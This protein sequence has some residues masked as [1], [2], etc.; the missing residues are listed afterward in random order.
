ATRAV[1]CQRPARQH[2]FE[3]VQQLL[4]DFEVALIAGMVERDQDLVREAPAVARYP[5]SAGM[6]PAGLV[7]HLV[8]RLLSGTGGSCGPRGRPHLVQPQSRASSRL[9]CGKS[10]PWHYALWPAGIS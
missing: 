10:I 1:R 9:D 6:L 2:H 5:T 4:R 8:C 3:N 7:L